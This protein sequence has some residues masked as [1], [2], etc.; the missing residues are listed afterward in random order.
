MKGIVF[1]EFQELVESTYGLEVADKVVSKGCPFQQGFTSVGTYDHHILLEMV[2][3][4]SAESRASVQELVHAFGKHLFQSFLRAY[5]AFFK[6]VGGTCE[7][8]NNVE[9]VIHRE[10]R[11]LYPDAELPHF[12]FYEAE[13]DCFKMEYRSTRPFA[14]LAGGLIEA[15]I[16]HF[17]EALAV[18]RLDLEG[19]P[20]T[21]ALFYLT[22]A[23]VPN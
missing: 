22:P 1:T 7:L 21:H 13:P 10:V 18:E 20:G 14:V 5:P 19:A 4:L 8:L 16:E 17:G 3:Q 6:D 2:G 23:L 11:K 9:T 15:S 12:Y